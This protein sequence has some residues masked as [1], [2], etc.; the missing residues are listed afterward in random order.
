[1]TIVNEIDGYSKIHLNIKKEEL[2]AYEKSIVLLVTI[3]L[4]IGDIL[5]LIGKG[6]FLIAGYN[7]LSESKKKQA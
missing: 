3:P 1:M 6:R 7:T 2:T 5:I 4:L